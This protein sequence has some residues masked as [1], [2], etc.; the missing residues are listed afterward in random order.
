MAS[1]SRWK[2]PYI[3]PMF[4]IKNFRLK[5]KAPKICIRNSVIPACLT[6]KSFYLYNGQKYLPIIVKPIMRGFKFG[7][8]SITKT[9]GY[10]RKKKNKKVR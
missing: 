6:L 10:K 9:L 3:A 2:V 5:R 7:E 1:R 8:F 4:F